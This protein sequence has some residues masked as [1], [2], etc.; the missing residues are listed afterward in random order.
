MVFS[1]RL[2]CVKIQA[3]YKGKLQST[4]EEATGTRRTFL[5][6]DLPFRHSNIVN[7]IL[8]VHTLISYYTFLI[9]PHF[10]WINVMNFEVQAIE[11]YKY[12]ENNL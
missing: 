7:I 10:L 5:P 1:S 12:I 11:Q 2:T 4:N 3:T 6:I 9:G 8:Y